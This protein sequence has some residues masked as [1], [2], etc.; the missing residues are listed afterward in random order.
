MAAQDE[1]ESGAIGSCSVIGSPMAQDEIPMQ[2]QFFPQMDP[3]P[4]MGTAAAEATVY[5]TSPP[6]LRQSPSP[7][8]GEPTPNGEAIAADPPNVGQLLMV[9]LAQMNGIKTNTDGMEKRMEGM[10]NKMEVN[11][12]QMKDEI[13]EMRGE[14]RQV[15]RCLQAGKMAPPR[16]PTNELGG[17]ATAVGPARELGEDRVIWETCRARSEEV[18]VT[19]RKKINGVTETCTRHVETREITS[20]VTELTGTREIGKIEERL[21]N[22]D[23]V[24]EEE[25]AHTHTHTQR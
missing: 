19:E 18:T 20:K 12:K 21:H 15:G 4:E 16:A 17:S 7:T 5:N 9:L 11:A 3:K 24:K 22:T 1:R 8:P 23:R 14:M 25:D 10:E 2:E 13:K 6:H